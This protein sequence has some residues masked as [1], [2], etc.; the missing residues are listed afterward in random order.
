MPPEQKLYRITNLSSQP[1]H[2][3]VCLIRNLL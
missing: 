1:I 2:F 3:P